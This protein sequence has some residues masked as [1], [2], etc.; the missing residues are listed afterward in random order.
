LNDVSPNTDSFGKKLRRCN[1]TL[2]AGFTWSAHMPWGN[3]IRIQ[4]NQCI[5]PRGLPTQERTDSCWSTS[6]VFIRVSAW[7]CIAD[8]LIYDKSRDLWRN[9]LWSLSYA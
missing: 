9:R 6:D 5:S 1:S 3:A 4:T 8:N 2:Q 7:R